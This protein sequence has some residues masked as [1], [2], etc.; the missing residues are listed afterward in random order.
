M[1]KGKSSTYR[2]MAPG[3]SKFCAISGPVDEIPVV[4]VRAPQDF[5]LFSKLFSDRG[6]TKKASLNA[7]AAALDD[8]SRLL[9]GFLITPLLVTGLGNFLYGSW[10]VLQELLGYIS[11]ATGRTSQALKWTLASQQAS[12]DYEK[13]RRDVGSTLVVW[14]VFLPVLTVLGGLLAWFVPF[15]LDAPKESFWSIR[16]AAG[17]LV[18]GLAMTS[19]IRIPRSVL[20]GEN[21]GYKRMG[22]SAF[23]VFVGGGFTWLAL[24]FDT[25]ITGVAAA[26]L[27]SSLLTGIVFLQ[28]ARIYIPWF[29]VARPSVEN[30]R[31]FL[32]LSWWFLAW[33]LVSRVMM[34][35][36]VVVLGMLD[37]VDLVTT[38]SLTKY[39]PATLIML[40]AIMV[41]GVT[42]GLGGIIGSGNL[43]KAAQVRNE[44]MLLTWLVV[45][46][47]G[48]TVLIWNGAFI[49]LWVGAEYYAGT[50]PTLLIVM[51]ITQLVLI[52]NDANIIDLTLRLRRKVLFGALSV[53]LSLAVAGVLVSYFK[54]KIVGLCLGFIVGRSVLSIGYPIIVGRFL[55]VSFSSQLKNM[56]RPAVVSTLIFV[57]AS[58]L[59][60]LLSAGKYFS[61]GGWIAFILSVGM[62][63]GLMLLLAAYTGLS[64]KQRKDILQRVRMLVAIRE[65]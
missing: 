10:R 57:I 2:P 24:F 13:K 45:T 48:P 5:R 8:G 16:L 12:C 36:D 56:L 25:G 6:L 61:S 34:G 55:N 15:W 60:D 35:S 59:G 9:V 27:A 38:Y 52:R 63:V 41:F 54:L 37:S 31:Q 23:M 18:A 43:A 64:G 32:G 42:P 17:I 20:E 29:G 47:L 58:N 14:T 11:P 44:I 40:V 62:T 30:V 53:T 28:I 51:G 22:L 33:T 46:V 26:A 65:N 1:G 7:L 39:A 3:D 21:L 50:I 4:R 19:L 49:R